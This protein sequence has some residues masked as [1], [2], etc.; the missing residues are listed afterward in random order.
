MYAASLDGGHKAL[1]LHIIPDTE[2]VVLERV[3]LVEVQVDDLLLFSAGGV[4]ELGRRFRGGRRRGLLL[5]RAGLPGGLVPLGG[6]GRL[7]SAAPAGGGLLLRLGRA[8][9]A[10]C[11]FLLD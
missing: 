7:A 11:L 2:R 3:E 8:A 1:H 10:T 6:L 9:L 5:G 4:F